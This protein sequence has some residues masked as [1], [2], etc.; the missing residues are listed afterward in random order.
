MTLPTP[1]RYVVLMQSVIE[2]AYAPDK[3]RRALLAS[4][5]RILSLAWET[6]YKTT[7]ELDEEELMEY[8][9]LSRRQYFEQKADME[10]LGWL[11]S[12]HPRPGFVRFSF[13]QKAI[14]AASSAE[15]PVS[16]ENRTAS[17]E[18]RTIESMIEDVS[19]SSTIDNSSSIN[20]TSV[21]KIAPLEMNDSEKRV[22]C[23][24]DNLNLIFEPR[25]HGKLNWRDT[26]LVG[27]PERLIGW[28]A[29]AYQ[30]R[31][32]L[33]LPLGFIVKHL[34]QNDVP[35]PYYTDNYMQIL[36]EIYL[37][38]IGDITV[39]MHVDVG[40][41]DEQT[42]VQIE[43]HAAD[44]ELWKKNWKAALDQL[45]LQMPRNTFDY[46]KDTMAIRYD[47]NTLVVGVP[48]DHL[49]EWLESRMQSTVDRL[50]VGLFGQNV[51]VQFV[52]V[53]DVLED[54]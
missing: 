19:I 53:A 20:R 50:L 42:F 31:E 49:R 18:N 13:S 8:L 40:S 7:P 6:K 21:R 25:R 29:K 41:G 45:K 47:G 52:V 9:K 26:F 5:I 38:A 11:R 17:A 44:D 48:N 15:E 54:A 30:D 32:R 4:F 22:K 46:V 24:V 10:L 37:A 3:P 27:M 23:L 36:P 14:E 16:A 33:N 51:N 43:T 28:I 12:S 35:D 34:T 39:E 2:Q 1:P